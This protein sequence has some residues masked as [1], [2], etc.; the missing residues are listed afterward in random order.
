MQA[1][2]IYHR[3]LIVA[4]LG[5][6]TGLLFRRWIRND[7]A[8][9]LAAALVS[10]IGFSSFAI[11]DIALQSPHRISLKNVDLWPIAI[12]FA[13]AFC[14]GYLANKAN[15]KKFKE[16]IVRR[17]MSVAIAIWLI[18]EIVCPPFVYT[19]PFDFPTSQHEWLWNFK[20]HGWVN[21]MGMEYGSGL[22]FAQIFID[23]CII[24]VFLL[25]MYAAMTPGTFTDITRISPEET[26]DEKETSNHGQ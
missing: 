9:S 22:G 25:L 3:L 13:C 24:S 4:I 20:N 14:S 8:A 1:V 6:F 5:G 11:L 16:A 7:F 17:T 18:I 15:G 19:S 2:E 26:L 23:V 12:V 10:T 21:D